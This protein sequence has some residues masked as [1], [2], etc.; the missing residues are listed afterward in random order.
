[1]RLFWN[2]VRVEAVK[3]LRPLLLWAGLACLA[4]LTGFFFATFFAFRSG[5]PA[6]ATHF[7]YWPDSLA[8]ALDNV[9][10]YTSWA[11]YGTFL[12]IV[13]VGVITGREYA[14]RTLQLWLG[15]GVPRPALVAARLLVTLVP[16]ALIVLTALVTI[17]GLS[18]LFSLWAQGHVDAGRVDPGQLALGMARTLFAMLPY[19]SLTFL[20]AVITRSTVA[21]VAGGLGFVLVLETT[22]ANTLPRLGTELGRAAQ[23]LPSGL[24]AALNGQNVA[25]GHVA[26]VTSPLQ[27]DPIVA[28]AG[29]AA[30][31]LVFCGLALLAFRRQDLSS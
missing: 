14:W 31:T 18:A 26:P 2:L 4:V 19:A 23:L 12:L 13:A 10:G 6:S 21:A 28:A 17:G 3:A 7:L 5:I 25:I 22:I 27:P 8:Y 16:A 24:S 29:I 1:M 15:C 11:S 30:Y 20:L 9:T